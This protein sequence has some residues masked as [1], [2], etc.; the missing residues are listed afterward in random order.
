MRSSEMTIVEYS[1]GDSRFLLIAILYDSMNALT[2]SA[3]RRRDKVVILTG[4]RF[5]AKSANH[6][7]GVGQIL[8]RA[9]SRA[10]RT[11]TPRR[12][13][14]AMFSTRVTTAAVFLAIAAMWW[15]N[16]SISDTLAAQRAAAIDCFISLPWMAVW[17]WRT[18]RSTAT[19]KGGDE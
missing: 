17:A 13:L 15:H 18:T 14:R 12:I 6:F 11:F 8:S 9:I 4:L 3:S 10:R 16:V 1:N 19:E 7:P 2:L 5:E